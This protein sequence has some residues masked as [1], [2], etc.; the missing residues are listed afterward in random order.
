MATNHTANYELNQWEATDSVLRTDFNADNAK[1]ETALTALSASLPRMVSGSY[2]G[3]GTLGAANP[4]TLQFNFSPKLVVVAASED[5]IAQ[6]GVVLVAGQTA[7]SGIGHASDASESLHLTVHWFEN[8]VS[9]YT[10]ESLA[11]CQ[12]NIFDVTY[13]YFAIG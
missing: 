3:D 12:L 4:T 10:N 13:Y 9:W 8:G 2:V 5:S 11:G 1:L 6:Q 7:S